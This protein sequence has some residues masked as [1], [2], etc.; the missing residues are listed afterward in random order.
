MAALEPHFAKAL[1]AAAGVPN[2]DISTMMSPATPPLIANFLLT[3]TRKALD[4][5]AV[6]KDIPLYTLPK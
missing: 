2:A 3:K 4:K 6:D 1:C 5:L